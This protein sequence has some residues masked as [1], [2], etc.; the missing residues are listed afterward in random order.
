[1][2]HHTQLIRV[3]ILLA[4]VCGI[5]VLGYT[6]IERWAFLD[7]LFM[8]IITLTTVGFGEVRPLT[9]SG[10][11]FTIFLLFIGVGVLLYGVSSLTAFIV[12]GDLR[13][14]LRKRKRSR[15][16]KERIA[17]LKDHYI[18]CGAGEI[19]THVIN[20]FIRMK[21]PF[22]VIERNHEVI[23]RL[24][25]REYIPFVEGNA[26]EDEVLR[27]AGIEQAKGLISVLPEDKD[28]LFTIVAART[29]QPNIRIVTKAVKEG[30]VSKLK[31]A[32]ANSVISTRAIGGMRI[33][34]E[35]LR[36]AV[37][38]FLDSIM[39]EHE[40]TLRVEEAAVDSSSSMVGMTLAQSQITQ[41]TGLAVIAVKDGE[42][43]KYTHNPG[44]NY[45]LRANDVLFVVGDLAQ[46][47]KLRE[48][49]SV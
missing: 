48:M 49:M 5:G 1:M 23:Q 33:A 24:L 25:E 27:R 31:R 12:E 15:K 3:V 17:A 42:Q 6:I 47:E 2:T 13:D 39:L 19:G 38:S 18:I 41:K 43:D 44:A 21:K 30:S 28:N 36:P 4:A 32:G 46:I 8:T 20:E 26:D 37:V 29:L 9:P 40:L 11:V 34:S 16:M 45:T 10:R 22:V 14:I 35:M 7:S